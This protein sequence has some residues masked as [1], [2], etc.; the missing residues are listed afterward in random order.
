MMPLSAVLEWAE[1]S[2]PNNT[3]DSTTLWSA[4]ERPGANS[5]PVSFPVTL[6]KGEGLRIM[7]R[8]T[9]IYETADQ[10]GEET[11]TAT[12]TSIQSGVDITAPQAD[13]TIKGEVGMCCS[14]V[15]HDLILLI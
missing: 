10:E 12:I 9:P 4:L 13:I 8:V 5:F 3:I 2:A 15:A 11:F 6:L 1:A 14:E 7:V